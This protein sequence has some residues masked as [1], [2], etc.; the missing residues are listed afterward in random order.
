ME[1]GFISILFLFLSLLAF[2]GTEESVNSFAHQTQV[3]KTL[4]FDGAK[5]TY[6]AKTVGKK[7]VYVGHISPFEMPVGAE[8]GD[9]WLFGA[10]KPAKIVD[11][12]PDSQTF[13]SISALQP[14]NTRYRIMSIGG[15]P[16][17]YRNINI[18]LLSREGLQLFGEI[19][20]NGNNLITL[21]GSELLN[22]WALVGDNM[23]KARAEAIR[24]KN[25]IASTES[26]EVYVPEKFATASNQIET[27]FVDDVPL[28][29]M[30]TQAEVINSTQFYWSGTE[31]FINF[32]PQGRKMEWIKYDSFIYC[33][34]W[35]GGSTTSANATSNVVISNLNICKYGGNTFASP[36]GSRT[37]LYSAGGAY[38]SGTAQWG[39]LVQNCN[40]YSNRGNG[41]YLFPK[42]TVKNCKSYANGCK[43]IHGNG[44]LSDD[45]LPNVFAY[46]IGNIIFENNFAGYT[47]KGGGGTAA[48]LKITKIRNM[49]VEGNSI[50]RNGISYYGTYSTDGLWFDVNCT[51]VE[52]RN[53]RIIGNAGSGFVFEISDGLLFENNLVQSNLGSWEVLISS[54]PNVI[55]RKNKIYGYVLG[56]NSA[57]STKKF[58]HRI[59]GLL[60]ATNRTGSQPLLIK[61][62]LVENNNFYFGI[63]NTII[64]VHSSVIEYWF[65]GK[66]APENPTQTQLSAF[67]MLQGVKFKSNQYFTKNVDKD[68]KHFLIWNTTTERKTL[69]EMQVLGLEKGSTITTAIF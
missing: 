16:T 66:F 1:K 69:A 55:V 41:L 3:R 32:N 62:V 64:G 33:G 53:N 26:A 51:G 36:V 18:N 28:V 11:W 2:D 20:P 68:K 4:Y 6:P 58:G 17:A 38:A 13:A 49:K 9:E 19:D 7:V 45:Y 59:L 30:L 50:Y 40:S 34:L 46:V 67:M 12:R 5:G 48:G 14:T 57:P 27:L 54:S 39:W 37:M 47:S 10:A 31:V 61:N 25:V 63:E 23:Y 21:N 24:N 29:P 43:G 42:S 8:V 56:E 60:H 22:G 65:Q 44:S 15:R 35:A 52:V